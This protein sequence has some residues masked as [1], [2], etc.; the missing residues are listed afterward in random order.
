MP[1]ENAFTLCFHRAWLEGGD[2]D[3]TAASLDAA[4][5]VQLACRVTLLPNPQVS[6]FLG[7][8]TLAHHVSPRTHGWGPDGTRLF[9]PFP[10]DP[11]AV[12]L[13]IDLLYRRRITPQ[14]AAVA[15]AAAASNAAGKGAGVGGETKVVSGKEVGG[16]TKGVG[17]S[18]SGGGA[19]DAYGPWLVWGR[20][21]FFGAAILRLRMDP[22]AF[23]MHAPPRRAK[24]E[25]EGM[26]PTHG[27][28]GVRG[29][30]W[31]SV[32]PPPRLPQYNGKAL[33]RLS[34]VLPDPSLA[35][36]VL[37]TIWVVEVAWCSDGGSTWSTVGTVMLG[38][39]APPPLS[40][41]FLG[42]LLPHDPALCALRLR[43]RRLRSEDGP[44]GGWFAMT[45]AGKNLI[46]GE[47][48]LTSTM[49][50]IEGQAARLATE[51][52]AMVVV[53]KR[54]AAEVEVVRVAA[55]TAR[56]AAEAA[57]EAAEQA[58]WDAKPLTR[59]KQRSCHQCHTSAACFLC[60]PN[61]RKPKPA[62]EE[63]PPR[64]VHAACLQCHSTTACY[65]DASEAFDADGDGKLDDHEK[66]GLY[67]EACWTGVYGAPPRKAPQRNKVTACFQCQS[68]TKC[69][70]ELEKGKE[71][72]KRDNDATIITEEPHLAISPAAVQVQKSAAFT[73]TAAVAEPS[74]AASSSSFCC[75]PRL[76]CSSTPAAEEAAESVV[77]DEGNTDVEEVVGRNDIIGAIGGG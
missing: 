46:A 47:G 74:G 40:A 53:R 67:C 12:E 6:L 25:I 48:R 35:V 50:E 42:F 4:G 72:K 26:D 41:T 5:P 2:G 60:Q 45:L 23:D 7:Q 32:V 52:A 39:G 64:C 15:A 22:A 55:E 3:A 56:V 1:K 57:H 36:Q 21:V 34:H 24:L 58:K 54:K 59:S 31:L 69:Y 75:W 27:P 76:S 68:S 51:E 10:T 38:V 71:Q 44:R 49:L 73:F 9:I 8:T 28:E 16:E 63:P 65:Q 17:G 62:S 20:S 43:A 19:E 14:E 37:N 33:L 18:G 13:R 29:R 70:K 66:G 11:A 30:L 61:V 77:D